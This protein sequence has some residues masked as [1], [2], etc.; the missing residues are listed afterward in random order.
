[1]ES[2]TLVRRIAAAGFLLLLA[3]CSAVPPVNR[4][5]QS[6]AVEQGL[7]SRSGL[8]P[9]VF[10][11]IPSVQAIWRP[12]GV[13]LAVFAGQTKKP[14]LEFWAL[15]IELDPPGGKAEGNRRLRILIGAGSQNGDGGLPRFGYVSST[16]V[17]SF[18]RDNGLAAGINTVPFDPSSAREGEERK[19][20]GLGIAGGRLIAPPVPRYDALVFYEDGGA[21]IVNQGELAEPGNPGGFA[22]PAGSAGETGRKILHAAGGFHSILRDGELTG[23]AQRPGGPRYARSAAGLSS[24]GRI[25]YLAVIN[26]GRISG[27][28]ATE[29][30]TAL[31]LKQLGAQ[32][33]LN[34]DGGGSSALVLRFPD[35]QAAVLNTPVHAGIPGRERAVALC[36]GI[37]EE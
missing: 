1:M 24:G 23:R 13:K 3:G 32:D 25:L 6:A 12:A 35:G 15:K 29:A 34:L 22:D 5:P 26:G 8:R 37:G 16:R 33:V 19:V 28:G 10:P 9:V 30:E 4:G 21:A 27:P 11:D 14:R 20:V 7:V 18:V 31:I 2:F 17:S 36:L